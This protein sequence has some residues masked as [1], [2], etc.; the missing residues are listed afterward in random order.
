MTSLLYIKSTFSPTKSGKKRRK[1]KE[2]YNKKSTGFF[3]C[4]KWEK[5]WGL[6]HILFPHK[7]KKSF[8]GS[9][10]S[11]YILSI[12]PS[13]YRGW[14][15]QSQD[16]LFV[17]LSISQINPCLDAP[18]IISHFIWS[19]SPSP[20][21]CIKYLPISLQQARW[22]LVP[23][24]RTGSTTEEIRNVLRVGFYHFLYIVGLE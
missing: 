24:T 22:P 3:D 16:V 6:Y 8:I 19:V 15:S 21:P 7:Q 11:L 5:P 1:E 4:W 23:V 18:P 20:W 13:Q 14:T 12:G 10:L 17:L 2:K 9:T